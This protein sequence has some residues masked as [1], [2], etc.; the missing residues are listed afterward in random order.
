LKW[1]VTT[2]EKV[3][4][5]TATGHPGPPTPPT[6]PSKRRAAGGY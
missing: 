3:K 1:A 2:Q 6:A 5:A 4:R